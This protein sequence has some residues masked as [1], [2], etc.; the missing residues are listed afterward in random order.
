[1]ACAILRCL[2]FASFTSNVIRSPPAPATA[3]PLIAVEDSQTASAT[4]VRAPVLVFRK[5]AQLA[6]PCTGTSHETYEATALTCPSPDS[7][8]PIDQTVHRGRVLTWRWLSS[9][10]PL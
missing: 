6:K 1:M 8:H 5:L 7:R 2:E 10:Q 9:L 4:V 3:R